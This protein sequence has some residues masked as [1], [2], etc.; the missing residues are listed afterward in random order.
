MVLCSKKY[1][2]D[3]PFGIFMIRILMNIGPSILSW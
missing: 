2:F 1:I 3:I